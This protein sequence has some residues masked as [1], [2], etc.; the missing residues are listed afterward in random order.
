MDASILTSVANDYTFDMIFARQ[1]E[2]A[3]EGDVALGLSTSG[4]SGN[5]TSALEY[6]KNNNLR[7]I[8]VTGQGGGRC[9]ELADILIDIP[10]DETPRIQEATELIF[11]ILCEL[12][13]DAFAG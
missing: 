9:G 13:E 7:T 8:A 10:S 6:A 1:L 3:N 11:H 5:V 12:V 2:V 4:N